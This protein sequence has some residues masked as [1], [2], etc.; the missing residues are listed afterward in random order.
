VAALADAHGTDGNGPSPEDLLAY[1]YA[2]L[3]APVYRRRYAALLELGFPRVP[4]PRDPEVFRDLAALGRRLVDLHL[5]RASELDQPGVRLE[6]P[7]GG[8]SL[9]AEP[10]DYRPDERRVVVSAEGHAF[11]GLEPGAWD[12]EIGGYRVLRRWLRERAGGTLAR[13]EIET[14][15]RTAAALAATLALGEDLDEGY[16]RVE[17][18]VLPLPGG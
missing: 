9:A 6:G 11:T 1:V 13:G 3:Q 17:E 7:P 14:F 10:A 15:C 12:L 2:V 16:E 5:L 8:V 18:G 4:F